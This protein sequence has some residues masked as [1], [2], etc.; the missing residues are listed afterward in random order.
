MGK[1]TLRWPEIF[2]ALC[3]LVGLEQFRNILPDC[4]ATYINKKNLATASAAAML[5]DEFVVLHKGNFKERT[6]ARS[7]PGG[8]GNCGCCVSC[9]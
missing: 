6:A 1:H 2:E 8:R 4:I 5:A 3:D 9:Q 7:E